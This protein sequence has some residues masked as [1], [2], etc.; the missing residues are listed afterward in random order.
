MQAVFGRADAWLDWDHYP[1]DRLWRSLWTV[2]V[3][4][5]GLFRRPGKPLL[6]PV[7]QVPATAPVAATPGSP[8]VLA[9]QTMVVPPRAALARR[10]RDGRRLRRRC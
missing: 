8:S 4:I 3:S 1:R 2:L 6:A 9:R 10:C 5:A 7:A